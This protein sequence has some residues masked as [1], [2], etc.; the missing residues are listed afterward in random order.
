MKDEH[1]E[2]R[3]ELRHETRLIQYEQ[4]SICYNVEV[5][6][7]PYAPQE[8][9]REIAKKLGQ[10]VG[11]PLDD[12]DIKV[13]DRVKTASN[14]TAPNI[15]TYFAHR[16]SRDSFLE[17]A[18]KPRLFSNYLGFQLNV[19]VFVNEH[20]CSAVKR[21]FGTTNG[22]RKECKW[23]YAWTRNGKVFFRESAEMAV[24]VIKIL[25]DISKV[26]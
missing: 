24:V 8:N 9:I 25:D 13:C 23:Q 16:S 4:H 1:D 22:K 26:V 17:K 2:L 5:R 21:L 14:T 15:V 11:E 12:S 20:L 18:R 3:A 6:G 7:V 10:A 19:P